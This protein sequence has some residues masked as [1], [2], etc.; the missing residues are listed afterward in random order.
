MKIKNRSKW[1]LAVAAIFTLTL[2]ACGN[3]DN[4]SSSDPG[5]SNEPEVKQDEEQEDVTIRVAWWGGQERHAL[6][7]EVIDL[8][9][10]KYPHITIEPEF[11]DWDGHW[12]KLTTQAGGGD[13]PDV[14]QM[15]I[16]YLNEYDGNGLL[17]DLTPFIANG[18][19]DLSDVDD[20]YQD[21]LKDGDRTLAI[22]LGANSFGL[23]YNQSL[24]EE[25]GVFL[26][27]GYTWDE[28]IDVLKDLNPRVGGDFHGFGFGNAGYE[29]FTVYARSA[30]ESIYNSEGT[31]LGFEEQ[32]LVDFFTMIKE[33]TDAGLTPTP[34]F[35]AGIVDGSE[36]W[37][38]RLTYA[39]LFASNQIVANAENTDQ[40][41]G[42]M[43][44]PEVEGGR[45][46]NWLRSSMSFAVTTHSKEQEAAALFIDFF[47]NDIEANKILQAERGVPIS[48][49][50]RE[51]LSEV[52]SDVV[53][54]TF[55]FLDV[56]AE[57]SSPA[58]PLPP[59]GETEISSAFSRVIEAVRLGALTPEEAA[60]DFMSQA[61]EILK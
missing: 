10:E 29:L 32:T 6:T 46:G 35:E 59:A 60:K 37:N 26:E 9:E 42:L 24:A 2:S 28:F 23:I 33:L 34:D 11:S 22:S 47:T 54:Q 48:S 1:L 55:D 44:L 16:Q 57:H 3:S 8:F 56:I 13:L 45:P 58:D 30:G 36:W 18:T 40:E 31:G 7:M 20:V 38:N 4:E 19:I 25:H 27:P 21:V 39:G 52:V 51:A 43:V 49:A 14:I 15:D 50:V 17:V 41:L 12:Q 5:D 61:E 53:V